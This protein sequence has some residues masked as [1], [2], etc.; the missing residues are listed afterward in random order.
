[1]RMPRATC[2]ALTRLDPALS[3]SSLLFS[4]PSLLFSSLLSLFPFPIARA[5]RGLMSGPEEPYPSVATNEPPI[6][7]AAAAA[8]AGAGAGAAGGAAAATTDPA[9]RALRRLTAAAAASA[10][11]AGRASAGADSGGQGSGGG[12]GT[13]APACAPPRTRARPPAATPAPAAPAAP[14]STPPL[15]VTAGRAAVL[16]EAIAGPELIC[17][18]AAV[19]SWTP[20]GGE[21]MSAWLSWVRML[22]WC[23]CVFRRRRFVSFPR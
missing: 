1:M 17:D 9:R 7:A 5:F 16:R 2:R 18:I 4:S 10:A 8:A 14:A 11:G 6:P 12:A 21:C 22:V 20:P 13:S 23:F 3:F 19:L 15:M